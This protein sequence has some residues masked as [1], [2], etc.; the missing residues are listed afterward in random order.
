MTFPFRKTYT[1]STVDDDR[2]T[3]HNACIGRKRPNK[4]IRTSTCSRNKRISGVG[5]LSDFWF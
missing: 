4:P 2:Q 5:G 3:P 1:N